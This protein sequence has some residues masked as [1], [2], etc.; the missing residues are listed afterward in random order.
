MKLTESDGGPPRSSQIEAGQL[1]NPSVAMTPARA[2]SQIPVFQTPRA[3][4]GL[5]SPSFSKEAP[6]TVLAP[7]LT[8]IQDRGLVSERVKAGNSMM[9]ASAAALP[10]TEGDDGTLQSPAFPSRKRPVLDRWPPPAG[11]PREKPFIDPLPLSPGER[12]FSDTSSSDPAN[13]P[14]KDSG[15]MSVQPMPIQYLPPNPETDH[16]P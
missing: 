8:K 9:Q 5:L 4:P 3:G 16:F 13:L 10:S 7:S 15:V 14:L 6:E 2:S 11:A 12:K 1:T